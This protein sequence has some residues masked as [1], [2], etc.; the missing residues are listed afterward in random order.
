MKVVVSDT[1]PLIVLSNIGEIEILKKLFRKIIIPKAVYEEFGKYYDWIEIMEVK[2]KVA[3]KILNKSLH[4]GESEAIIL[5][6]E[7]NADLLIV[8]DKDARKVASDLGLNIIGTVGILLLAKKKGYY[9]EIKPIIDK[10]LE[11]G[12]RL[13]KDVVE[14]VLKEADEL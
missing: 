3:V 11:K 1:S 4:K 14:Y 10:L 9:K 6:I 2:N 7:L 5:S 13:S 12:F 8:D